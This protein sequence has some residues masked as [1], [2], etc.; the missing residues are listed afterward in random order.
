MLLKLYR[1]VQKLKKYIFTIIN[2]YFAFRCFDFNLIYLYTWNKDK[3]YNWNFSFPLLTQTFQIWKSSPIAPHYLKHI[4]FMKCD[5]KLC[6]P[7]VEN[8]V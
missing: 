6:C 4:I 1:I 8:K 7:L 3:K 2:K 5:N